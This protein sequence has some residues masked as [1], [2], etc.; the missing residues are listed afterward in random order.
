MLARVHS[1]PL[2]GIDAQPVGVEV[3]RGPVRLEPWSSTIPRQSSR[4][5]RYRTDFREIRGQEFAKRAVEVAAAGGHNV[6][7]LCP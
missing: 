1:G 7:A 4:F 2:I 6:L 5:G 3:D